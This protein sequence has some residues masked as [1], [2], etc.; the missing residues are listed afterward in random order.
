MKLILC[1]VPNVLETCRHPSATNL[2][3]ASEAGDIPVVSLPLLA[4]MVLI[5]DAI[6]IS[7]V[8]VH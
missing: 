8:G 2:S 4:T 5:P 3:G 7:C 6:A 1:A